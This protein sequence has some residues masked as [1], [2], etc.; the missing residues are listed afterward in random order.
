MTRDES[1]QVVKMILTYWRVRDWSKE[2]M[3][4]FAKGIQHLDVQI[5]VSALAVASRELKYPPRIAEFLEVYRAERSRLRA[6]LPPEVQT[7]GAP[8]P[9]WVKR[10][11]CARLLHK[12]FD[13]EQ[14]MRR[15]VEQGDFGDLTQEVM[16]EGAWV[17]EA[18]M[19][20][21]KEF[22][23]AFQQLVRS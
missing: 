15:F 17:D 16:P 20:D 13:K 5:A 9:F 6:S 12:R 1:L 7:R 14:D 22:S 3:D 23:K 10:W 18:N 2:E 11:I 19:L 4:A 21:D 8:Y